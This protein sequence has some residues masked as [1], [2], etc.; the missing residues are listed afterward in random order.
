MDLPGVCLSA[1]ND[2][3]LS[4]VT[5]SRTDAVTSSADTLATAGGGYSYEVEFKDL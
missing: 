2:V 1:G 4:T 5:T 3:T